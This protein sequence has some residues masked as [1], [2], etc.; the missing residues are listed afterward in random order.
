MIVVGGEAL[1]DLVPSSGAWDIGGPLLP[2]W[3]GAPFN[4][5]VALGRLAV[6]TRF[7]SRLS[8]DPFGVALLER[9]HGAGVDTSLVQRGPEPTALAVV[10]VGA[11]GS[12][13]YSFHFEGTADRLVTDPGPLPE[14][15]TAVALG[16]LS[17]VLQPGASA[18]LQVLH[19][20]ADAG[21]LISLDPNIRPALIA[22]PV[23]YR[24]CF[25]SWLPS[26][27]LL[28]MS[29]E[30]AA[31]LNG[32]RDDVVQAYEWLRAGATAVV[33]T[34]GGGGLSAVTQAGVVDVPALPTIVADTIGAGDTAHAAVLARLAAHGALGRDRLADLDADAWRDVL[35]FAA[36]AAARTCARPGAEPP[37]AAEL[38]A[39]EPA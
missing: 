4:V 11:D 12:A 7:L 19:R 33:I 35:R 2:R 31:W 29:D 37:T 8:E 16:S 9:L 21:R 32:D 34:R 22:D 25:V 6:P 39:P 13:R 15:T 17:L 1:V 38:D 5:A 23:A 36:V 18:Y 10:T 28:K 20:E 30:D 14:D 24:A 27:G 3:G 26:I